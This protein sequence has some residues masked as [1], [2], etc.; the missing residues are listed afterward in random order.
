[1]DITTQFENYDRHLDLYFNDT[2][3]KAMTTYR[4]QFVTTKHAYKTY[5]EMAKKEKLEPWSLSTIDRRI[6]KINRI[7][8][9]FSHQSCNLC[10]KYKEFTFKKTHRI[11][12]DISKSETHYK[13]NKTQRS[14]YLAQIN[15]LT[16]KSLVI[17][18]DFS[19][20]EFRNRIGHLCIVTYSLV[21]GERNV[22]FYDFF[23]QKTSC[24]HSYV[25]SSVS[26]LFRNGFLA[27]YSKIDIWTDGCSGQ[28]KNRFFPN[29]LLSISVAISTSIN[30]NFFVTNHG[31]SISDAGQLHVKKGFHNNRRAQEPDP[32]CLAD[33]YKQLKPIKNHTFFILPELIADDIKTESDVQIISGIAK[34]H[35]IKCDVNDSVPSFKLYL[36]S[37]TEIIQQTLKP[38][39][40]SYSCLES[41]ITK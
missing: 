37:L 34:C 4:Y 32:V 26:E 13:T 20:M 41:L 21:N 35:R 8:R 11:V 16:D 9:Q 17:V 15:N 3:F 18:M 19:S 29:F 28:F 39:I 6:I 7:H 36:D 30:L 27:G 22:V 25:I 23:G 2:N 12:E 10:L 14:V 1:L 31:H 5:Y 33:F 40:L 24:N 38:N